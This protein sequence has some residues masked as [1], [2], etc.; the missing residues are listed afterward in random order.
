M[1]CLSYVVFVLGILS[2]SVC[3]VIACLSA[4]RVCETDTD[5]RPYARRL[6]GIQD[7]AEEGAE[8]LE[9]FEFDPPDPSQMDKHELVK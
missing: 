8:I 7:R 9:H 1:S 5:G 3:L 2:S 6:Q 4:P